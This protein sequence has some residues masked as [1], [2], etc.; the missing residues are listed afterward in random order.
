MDVEAALERARDALLALQGPEGWWKAELE[1]N[2]TMDAEDLL[3]RRFLGID[4]PSLAERSANWIRSRQRSDG[5]WSTFYEGPPDL[6]TTIEAYVALRLAGDPPDAGHMVKA[7]EFVARRRRVRTV[8]RASRASGWRCSALWSWR[9]PPGDAARGHAPAAV[10]TR[11]HLRL[12]VLGPPDGRRAHRRRC[13]PSGARPRVR[14]RRAAEWIDAAPAAVAPWSVWSASGG[15]RSGGFHLLDRV[16]HAYERRPFPPLRRAAL[17]GGG[18]LDRRPPGGRRLVGRHPAAVGLLADRAAPPRLP[19]RPSRDGGRPRRP[20]HVHARGRR[21]PP[22]RGVPVAGVGHRARRRRAGRRRRRAA[23]TPRSCA[24]P[25]GS[26]ARR[27]GCAATG[28][29]AG[30]ISNRPVGRSSSRTSTTPT[31][32]TPPR[33]SSRCGGSSTPSRTASTPRSS[34]RSRGSAACSAATAAGPRSTSTTRVA[35][36]RSCRSA[37]SVRSSTRPARTSPPTSSRCSPRSGATATR[38]APGAASTGWPRRRRP[39]GRGSAVGA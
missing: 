20:R 23:T 26:S 5:T 4:S 24:R 14:H 10:V 29:S 13:V 31:S 9:R 38:R 17:R 36:R 11:Q 3:L 22:A 32:T 18:A 16:L 25:T 30:P 2:V 21:E 33:S 8:A 19:D 37:T 27:S 34:A 1:T 12:R 35:G 6:S 39:T 15:F 7:S 28:A